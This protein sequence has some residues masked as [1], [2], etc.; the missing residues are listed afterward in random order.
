MIS[1]F[2]LFKCLAAVATWIAMQRRW[3]IVRHFNHKFTSTSDDPGSWI[4]P[5]VWMDRLWNVKT[6]YR[7]TWHKRWWWKW[8]PIQT[9]VFLLRDSSINLGIKKMELNDHI[10]RITTKFRTSQNPI[11]CLANRGATRRK[12]G[13]RGS[14]ARGV[15]RKRQLWRWGLATKLS[16]SGLV[17]SFTLV[18][19]RWL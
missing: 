1:I 19:A 17:E 10:R 16:T 12:S 15:R 18:W 9:V 7:P 6:S 8:H 5:L 11:G 13:R 3:N 2:S 14:P 4:D